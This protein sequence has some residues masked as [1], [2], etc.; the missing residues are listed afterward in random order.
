MQTVHPHNLNPLPPSNAP[1]NSTPLSDRIFSAAFTAIRYT[2]FAAISIGSACYLQH[3]SFSLIK[4]TLLIGNVTYFMH[5][6]LAIEDQQNSSLELPTKINQI[7]L[8]ALCS[9]LIASA[10]LTGEAGQLLFR[11]VTSFFLGTKALTPLSAFYALSDITYSLGYIIPF[12]LYLFN[13]SNYLCEK[14]NTLASDLQKAYQNCLQ[15]SEEED[16][17][18]REKKFEKIFVSIFVSFLLSLFDLDLLIKVFELLSGEWQKKIFTLGESSLSISQASQIISRFPDVFPISFLFE[19][20]STDRFQELVQ[21]KITPLENKLSSIKY[22]I[23]PFKDKLQD[24]EAR[25]KKDENSNTLKIEADQLLS[26]VLQN[27]NQISQLLELKTLAQNSSSSSNEDDIK[28]LKQEYETLKS[29]V[30]DFTGSLPENEENDPNFIALGQI[31]FRTSTFRTLANRLPI[32][33]R[34]DQD[35]LTEQVCDFLSEQGLATRQDLTKH[36]I[37]KPTVEETANEIVYFCTRHLRILRTRNNLVYNIFFVAVTALQVSQQPFSTLLGFSVGIV[38][39]SYFFNSISL[40][41]FYQSPEP[42][43]LTFADHMRELNSL[44][45]LVTISLRVGVI[46]GIFLGLKYAE[47]TYERLSQP[48]RDN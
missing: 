13:K 23:G 22:S 37:L 32:P 21:F 12:A 44:I 11:D 27:I 18:I 35:N 15:A 17:T 30:E 4:A 7:T 48:Q 25:Q 29:K 40:D 41:S 26:D 46:G 10:I 47:A 2:T 20:L 1:E 16:S 28:L 24:L 42:Q 36:K 8:V 31:G 45:L 33:Q 3:R 6:I 43:H 39:P 9:F 38:N 14:R 5:S 34:R 19:T